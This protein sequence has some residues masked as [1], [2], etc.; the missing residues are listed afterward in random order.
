MAAYKNVCVSAGIRSGQKRALDPLQLDYRSLWAA[1]SGCWELIAASR[2][3]HRVLLTVELSLQSVLSTT[4]IKTV[5]KTDG[6]D[7]WS[8]IKLEF[9]NENLGVCE[10]AFG[11]SQNVH[12]FLYCQGQSPTL[13]SWVRY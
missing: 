11:D 4:W 13:Y 2:E 3:E 5:L 9:Q 7:T 12:L 6:S 10:Y 8:C 1:W